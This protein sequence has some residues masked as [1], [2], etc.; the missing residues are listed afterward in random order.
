VN[1]DSRNI[2]VRLPTIAKADFE[3]SPIPRAN[4]KAKAF[5]I[6]LQCDSGVKVI[7]QI[8][9]AQVSG[10]S[11]VL[12]N[13]SGTGMATGVGVTLFM[14]DLTSVTRL[15]LASRF[16]HTTTSSGNQ[17]VNIPLTARY[18]RTAAT[19]AAMGAGLVSATAT[20]TLTY[21]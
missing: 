13:A 10:A 21:E 18:Y 14:G 7:Y 5:N 1:A 3:D 6:N 15:P 8:D 16:L 17:P 19:S 12:A 9:G 2:D 4:D 11:N 20:F